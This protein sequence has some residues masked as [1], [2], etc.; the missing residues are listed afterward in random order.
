MPYLDRS[1]FIDLLEKLSTGSDAVRFAV[2]APVLN[3]TSVDALWFTIEKVRP[4]VVVTE[5]SIVSV[6]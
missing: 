1:G 6:F 3:V 5:S 4:L 2:C